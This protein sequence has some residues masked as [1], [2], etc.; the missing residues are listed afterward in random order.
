MHGHGRGSKQAPCRHPPVVQTGRA[1]A[2]QLPGRAS[3]GR[4][5]IRSVVLSARSPHNSAYAT[6]AANPVYVPWAHVGPPYTEHP[7]EHAADALHTA[8]PILTVTRTPTSAPA[9]PRTH[10]ALRTLRHVRR[11]GHLHAVPAHIPIHPPAPHVCL[12]GALRMRCTDRTH[13]HASPS[14][15]VESYRHVPNNHHHASHPARRHISSPHSAN[16]YLKRRAADHTLTS[17]NRW[18]LQLQ[19]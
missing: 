16:R 15:L 10:T 14:P 19:G 17:Q 6:P 4:C 9:A 5:S 2:C 13:G 7:L 1:A 8:L 12:R 11:T 3:S 18:T